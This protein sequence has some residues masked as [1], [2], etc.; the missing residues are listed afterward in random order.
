MRLCYEGT[1]LRRR[2]ERARKHRQIP[3]AGVELL[4]VGGPEG[5]LELLRLAVSAAQKAGLDRFVLDCGHADIA[6]SMVADL[7]PEV[8]AAVLDALAQKDAARI[9]T[10]VAR[11]PIAEA[12]RVA[13]ERLPSLHGD[14]AVW[15]AAE[16]LLRR[17][18]AAPA[19]D[20]LHDLWMRAESAGL[21]PV[22][23]VDLGEVRGFAY[24]TGPIFHL[25]ADGPG[26]PLGSGGRYD[27]LLA[28][29]GAPM[30]AAGFAFDLDNLAWSLRAAGKGAD[31]R[32]RVLVVAGERSVDLCDRLRELGIS[33]AVGPSADP[34]AYARAWGFSCVLREQNGV[35]MLLSTATGQAE[36]LDG[37]HAPG[38][39][40]GGPAAPGGAGAEGLTA[41]VLRNLAARLRSG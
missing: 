38:Q 16:A 39:A 30:E 10:L 37:G 33:C 12:T 6:R 36:P 19:L 40:A 34:E 1:V 35:F 31:A 15:P 14:R 3:Q 9:A 18:P 20:A 25:F 41:K 26:E 23:R 28:R 13:L 7:R 11:E 32:I 27:D 2:Q 17:T 21:E 22:L 29:F 4:G 8:A 5:D 24:Y